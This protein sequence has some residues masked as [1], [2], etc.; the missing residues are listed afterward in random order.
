MGKIS[1]DFSNVKEQSGFNS[2]R[3]AA[4][5]YVATISSVEVGK[6]KADKPMV[7]F[8]LQPKDHASAVYPYYC[9]LQE[10]QLW[11]MRNVLVACGVKVP[12]GKVS[13]D[14]ERLMGKEL[15][16]ALEDDEY[17]GKERSTVEAVFP[18]HDVDGYDK[19]E[20]PA[21]KSKPAKEEADDEDESTD[22]EDDDD[23][24]ELDL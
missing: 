6:S 20:K 4:G 9:V 2:K 10:N 8:G 21:K 14:P 1:M 15:G 12:K 19:G 22:A 23:L 11:K 17:E 3:L 18:A 16:I 24:D 13:I 5:D 7:I